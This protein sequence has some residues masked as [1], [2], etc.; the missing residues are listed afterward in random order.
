MSDFI[1]FEA[2]NEPWGGDRPYGILER[3][4]C[5]DGIRLRVCRTDMNLEEAMSDIQKRIEEQ[6]A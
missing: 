2:K 3:F 1:L 5:S 4:K 6:T